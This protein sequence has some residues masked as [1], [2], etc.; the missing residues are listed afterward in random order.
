MFPKTV[1]AL[2]DCVLPSIKPGGDKK[3]PQFA[4]G[5]THC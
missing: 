2:T 4:L 1:T 5:S 3:T